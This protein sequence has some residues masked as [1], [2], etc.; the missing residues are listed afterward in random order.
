MKV[1]LCGMEGR[2]YYNSGRDK[3]SCSCDTERMRINI[4]IFRECQWICDEIKTKKEQTFSW[5][6]RAVLM[7]TAQHGRLILPL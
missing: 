7:K 4:V 6:Y 5:L 1:G 2:P 3:E